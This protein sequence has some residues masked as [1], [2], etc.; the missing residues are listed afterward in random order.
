[1]AGLHTPARWLLLLAA[2][3]SARLGAAAS[4]DSVRR[5]FLY[6]PCSATGRNFSVAALGL[7][8]GGIRDA[9]LELNSDGASFGDVAAV[10]GKAMV[11]CMKTHGAEAC[12]I[13][14][15]AGTGAFCTR[16]QSGASLVRLKRD[17]NV[18]SV[19]PPCNESAPTDETLLPSPESTVTSQPLV[20]VP[21]TELN[22]GCV[23]IKHLEG[24]VLQHRR[25][26]RRRVLCARGF[27][28][29]PNHALIV[30]GQWTSMRRLCA[31]EWTCTESVTLVNNLKVMANTRAV[32]SDEIT[33]TPYDLRFPVW[34]IWVV[35]MAEEVLRLV[36]LLGAFGAAMAAMSVLRYPRSTC[37]VKLNL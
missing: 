10:L 14:D 30:R 18:L 31:G 5:G 1:M 3:Y 33:V 24:Y 21:I 34:T 35:Q 36:V 6:C 15:A 19:A 22:E 26:L 23:A 9:R 17:S 32:V 16:D 11:S 12:V 27:C 8:E 13:A 29:T 20:G 7:L 4:D 2:L 37:Y 28:A 25:H